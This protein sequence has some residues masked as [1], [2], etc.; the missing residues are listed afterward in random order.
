MI[1]FFICMEEYLI[2][3][4]NKSFMRADNLFR[5]FIFDLS[6]EPLRYDIDNMHYY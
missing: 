3:E 6:I 4:I 5:F 2:L 1:D